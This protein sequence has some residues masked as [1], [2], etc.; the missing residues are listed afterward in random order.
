[1]LNSDEKYLILMN[2]AMVTLIEAHASDEI[3]DESII[4]GKNSWLY[5][6]VFNMM[7]I[8]NIDENLFFWW[9]FISLMKFYY[10]GEKYLTAMNVTKF[11]W[12]IPHSD[13]Q[14]GSFDGCSCIRWQSFWKYDIW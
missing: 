13:E 5:L 11:W 4:F 8:R 10:F 14:Y 9:K 2:N 12:K 6:K 1:M 7:K 3:P